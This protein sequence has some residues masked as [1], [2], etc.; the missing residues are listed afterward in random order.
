[1]TILWTKRFLHIFLRREGSKGK[2]GRLLLPRR[3]LEIERR[4]PRRRFP[5]KANSATFGLWSANVTG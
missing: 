1:M 5:G 2:I 3:S 4:Q